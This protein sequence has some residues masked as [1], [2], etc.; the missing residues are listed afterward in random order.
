MMQKSLARSGRPNLPDQPA[1][2][3]SGNVL[4]A[5]ALAPVAI[6]AVTAWS[7]SLN[8]ALAADNSAWLGR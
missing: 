7:S 2:R 8:R 5:R 1:Y 4:A 3:L 6:I